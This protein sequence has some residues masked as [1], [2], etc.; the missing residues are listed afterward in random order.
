VVTAGRVAETI[1]INGD[2]LQQLMRRSLVVAA[3]LDPARVADPPAPVLW[4]N[5][6]SR[7]LV[8][9]DG[10]EV[11]CGSGFVDVSLDVE[12]DQTQRARVVT[13]FVT[14]SP[15]R[16]G[17]FVWAAENRPRGPGP[18]VL[19]WGDALVALSWR[20]LVDVAVDAAGRS[21]VDKFG[22]DAIAATVVATRE[23][24][25]IIPVSAPQFMQLAPRR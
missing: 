20:A 18:V 5:G 2:E 3:G 13:T 15:D 7:L 8:H 22:R 1:T 16:P 10:F 9:L 12:C 11:R 25:R 21:G 6:T 19:V 4:D 23:G 24:L 14:S 17:G